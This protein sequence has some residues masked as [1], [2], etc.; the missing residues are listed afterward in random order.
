MGHI[1]L[2]GG[3][4]GDDDSAMT[5]EDFD[6]NKKSFRT[7]FLILPKSPDLK[8]SKFDFQGFRTSD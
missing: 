5:I 2:I 6:T 4:S 8:M 7:R 3:K 1:T